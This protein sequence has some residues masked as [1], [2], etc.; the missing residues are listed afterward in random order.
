MF[1]DCTYYNIFQLKFKQFLL[2]QVIIVLNIYQRYDFF[3]DI[4]TYI[5]Q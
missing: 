4:G 3:K 1:Y 2:K 5:F